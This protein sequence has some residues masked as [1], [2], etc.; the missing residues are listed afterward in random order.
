[1][2]KTVSLLNLGLDFQAFFRV[3]F[4]LLLLLSELCLQIIFSVSLTESC[5][6]CFISLISSPRRPSPSFYSVTTIV[7]ENYHALWCSLSDTEAYYSLYFCSIS[8]PSSTHSIEW[9]SSTCISH[10][11]LRFLYKGM[12]YFSQYKCIIVH[13]SFIF[14]ISDTAQVLCRLQRPQWNC[15]ISPILKTIRTTYFILAVFGRVSEVTNL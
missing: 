11:V 3:S 12:S 14:R 9:N 6:V 8:S 13:I 7:L 4:C 15:N 2:S 10:Q 1:M 5:Y